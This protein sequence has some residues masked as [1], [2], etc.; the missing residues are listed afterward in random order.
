VIIE[1]IPNAF[2]IFKIHLLIQKSVN[3]AKP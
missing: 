3:T 1:R 2:K